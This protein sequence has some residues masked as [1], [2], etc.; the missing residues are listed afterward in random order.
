M[1]PAHGHGPCEWEVQGV[2]ERERERQ[3]GRQTDRDAGTQRQREPARA[4]E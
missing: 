1:P 3:T 4:C 2:R